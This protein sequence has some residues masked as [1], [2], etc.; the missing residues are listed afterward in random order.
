MTRSARLSARRRTL[1][2]PVVPTTAASTAA[3]PLPLGAVRITG[4]TWAERQRV[5]RE[6]SIPVGSRR[7]REAGNLRNLELAAEQVA[8]PSREPRPEAYQGPVFMD[9][10]IYKWLEAVLWEHAREPSP[11][12]LDEVDV[13]SEALARAQAADGYLNS[14]VQVT[15]AD[16]ERYLDL[17]MGHE[18]YCFGHLL[19]AGGRGPPSDRRLSAVAGRAAG[20]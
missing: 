6:V 18:H 16:Q 8:D 17:A 20:G 11:D 3:S 1:L 15:R 13:F 9:S 2:G 12:L 5:N 19:Q 10:D 14:Y 4:G 7:L